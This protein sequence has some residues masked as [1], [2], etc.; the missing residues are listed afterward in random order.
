MV[1]IV[2]VFV[3]RSQPSRETA[4]SPVSSLTDPQF[5]A[6]DQCK[7]CH[8][9]AFDAW[10]GSNHAKAMQ[11]ATLQT[12]LGD[13]SGTAF[14]G[15]G[16]QS[17]FLTRDGKFFVNAIGA[18]GNAAD[19]A[20]KYTFGVEPLQQYLLA[21]PGG[22]LQ[23]YSVAWDMQ[24]ERWFDL[25]DAASADPKDEL[26]WAQP[27]YNWNFMCA[28]CHSTD[29]RKNY[30]PARHR[31]DTTFSQMNVGCQACHGPASV[32]MQWATRTGNE[33]DALDAPGT[34][35]PAVGR[36]LPASNEIE[37]CALCH[38]R[39]S[40]VWGEYRYGS[41]LMDTHVP[42][43]LDAPLYFADG[44]IRDEVYEYG[45]FLQS[46]M[47]Q[48]GVR[49][50]DCHEPHSS[51]LR[52]AGNA[53]CI[54]CHNNSAPAL[55]HAIDAGTLRKAHYDSPGHHFHSPGSPGA[56]CVDCH[57]PPRTYMKVQPRHDHSLRVPRPDLSAELGTPDACTS[58]HGDRTP[59]WAASR[60]AA[61]YGPNRRQEHTYG[62]ALHA[63]RYRKPGAAQELASLIGNHE[64]PA[65]VRATAL[66]LLQQYP[67][68]STLQLLAE[69]LTDRAPLVRRAA[70]SGFELL[71]PERRA[72]AA[73]AL[74][75]DPV[76]AVR[77]EA[78][79]LLAGVDPDQLGEN[80]ASLNKAIVE[81]QASQRANADRPESQLNLGNL[82]AAQGQFAKAQA[83]FRAALHLDA[84]F[85]AAYANLADLKAQQDQFAEAEAIL[86]TG[87]KFRPEAAALHHALGL[88]LV[89]RNE[90]QQALAELDRAAQ[91]APENA[92]YAYV[93][94]I[95]LHDVRDSKAGIAALKLALQRFPNDRDLLLALAGY[96]SEVGDSTAA[97]S[98]IRRLRSIEGN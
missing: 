8:A 80:A 6:E 59:D 2:T 84:S 3:W 47:Y 18:D 89:R 16:T 20:V 14:E 79:R 46:K 60:I 30:D 56:Q 78:A 25:N 45:S 98:Y 52:A 93:H 17:K 85:A 94:A 68:D 75:K 81:Y 34:F 91:L 67:T 23:A 72:A 37:T 10:A 43:L 24:Q 49:C 88:I 74:L 77:L 13:F 7:Q 61:W 31:Y 29:V 73:L 82:H 97:Q 66:T 95:A 57:M 86:R 50:S 5:V 38:S 33:A 69:N 83:A 90:R 64:Q 36:N 21:M 76:R 9:S 58:C 28:E 15:N 96:A 1:A 44:Q 54:A 48:K 32:H 11:A 42:V 70:A 41:A 87:L 39:R 53:L 92:R 4:S 26:H 71:P 62:E 22:R 51:K 63:G 12:V 40:V 55:R 35:L 19:F 27:A 65:I